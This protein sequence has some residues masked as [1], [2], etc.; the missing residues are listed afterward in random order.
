MPRPRPTFWQRCRRLGRWC[1]KLLLWTL[2]ALT[3]GFIYLNQVG[4]PEFCKGS[5]QAELRARGVDLEY[6][7]LRLRWFLGVVAESVNLGSSRVT[8]GPQFYVDE[9]QIHLNHDALWR[10]QLKVESLFLRR[11]KLVVPIPL[12]PAEPENFVVDGIMAQLKFQPDGRWELDQFQANCLG[13]RLRLTG[14]FTNAAAIRSTQPGA[15]RATNAMAVLSQPL[16]QSALRQ[17]NRVGSSLQFSNVPTLNVVVQGDVRE[18][19][20]FHARFQLNATGARTP[21]GSLSAL[22]VSGALNEPP[23]LAAEAHSVVRVRAND[24]STRWGSMAKLDIA[25]ALTQSFTNP[26]PSAIDWSISLERLVTPWLTL[27]ATRVQAKTSRQ[28]ESPVL[29]RTTGQ[30]RAAAY[31][32]RPLQLGPTELEFVTEH[33]LTS[34]IPRTATWK[35]AL[36]DVKSEQVTTPEV[37][38]SGTLTPHANPSAPAAWGDWAWLSPFELEVEA[39]SPALATH[40]LEI[41]ALSTRLAWRAP[42]LTLHQLNGDLLQGVARLRGSLDVETRAA[43]LAGRVQVDSHLL[44]PHLPPAANRFLRQFTW[45]EPP[46][47]EAQVRATLPPWQNRPRGWETNLLASLLLEGSVAG[48]N[49][50]YRDVPIQLAQSHLRFEQGIFSMPDLHL[51]RPEGSIDATYRV[52]P[53]T[54]EFRWRV[55]DGTID[56]QALRPAL[57]EAAVALDIVQFGAPLRLRADVQG[58]YDQ[59][60]GIGGTAQVQLTNIVVRGQPIDYLSADLSF[61]N[62]ILVATQLELRHQGMPAGADA[63]AYD[64]PRR[65]LLFT[66]AHGKLDPFVITKIIGPKTDEA[67][68]PYQFQQP[69]EIVLNGQIATMGNAFDNAVF[70]IRGGPFQWNR[71]H[72]PEISGRVNWRGQSLTISNLQGSFYGGR[73]EG[74]LTVL[75]PPQ[76]SAKIG[77][78]MRVEN[79][80]LHELLADLSDPTNKLAGR[81]DGRL[82]VDSLLA[83]D[84]ESWQGGGDVRLRNGF[85]WDWPFF[86]V[87]SSILNAVVPGIGSSRATA[88]SAT[89]TITN[90][91][92]H[93]RDMD[94]RSSTMRLKYVGTVD[95]SGR[96]EARVEAEILRDAWVLGRL[97]SL[98]MKPISKIFVYHVTG[99]LS[100][101]KAEPLHVPKLLM[102]PLQPIQT[103]KGLFGPDK[104]DKEA[105]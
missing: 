38:F 69:P 16:W 50:A 66:N 61:T 11:G 39:Q 85:L 87:F 19:A 29:L 21:W 31:Q 105:R 9:V 72:L 22:L 42:L 6:E 48:T 67:L 15:G 102:M 1:R 30:L 8:R 54:Q 3:A 103:L 46:F 79:T 73:I 59:P 36:R 27:P 75:L 101:P 5:I 70:E 93:T 92:I 88:G 4:L 45:Q 62:L 43:E 14:V 95:F 99:T 94:I 96:V 55:L 71:F 13:A 10:R 51:E 89:Y 37:A 24:A 104:S 81:L 84:W 58:R 64:I 53:A 32:S 28:D 52:H 100:Q 23:G 97:V 18:P 83:D 56:P 20:S 76:E 25:A 98:A 60:Q 17:V 77:F 90:S 63:L 47:V 2:L 44:E 7:R 49:V 78:D 40:G 35:G 26:V 74:G 33:S 41:N 65:M 82:R 91:V 12:S 57:D 34:S 80:D 68:R 86:G